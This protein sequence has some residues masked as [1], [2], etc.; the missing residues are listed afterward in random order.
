MATF[1]FFIGQFLKIIA[2]SIS[3]W[4]LL[5]ANSLFSVY[6]KPFLDKINQILE[7]FSFLLDVF[8]FLL[9]VFQIIL[10]NPYDSLKF[11]R[12]VKKLPT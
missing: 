1:S 10:D 3:Y 11:Q 6:K 4:T 7:H 9:D 12:I 2:I 5:H 8:S